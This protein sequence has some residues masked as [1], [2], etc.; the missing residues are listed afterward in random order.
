MRQRAGCFLS[1]IRHK[2]FRTAAMVHVLWRAALRAWRMDA[3][4]RAMSAGREGS[5]M[6]NDQIT[7][8]RALLQQAID[9]LSDTQ[10]DG[11]SP[12]WDI[13]KAAYDALRTAL[14]QP[15]VEPVAWTPVANGLPASG[16][17][18]LACYRNGMGNLRRIRA[19]WV[20][21][22]TQEVNGSD[23]C[24]CAEYDE[25]TDTFYIAQGWHERIDNWGDYSSV[26]V[27]EGEV[28]HWMPLPPAPDAAPQAQQ[29]QLLTDEEIKEAIR[30]LYQDETALQM[31]MD[32]T[33]HEFRAIEQAVHQ[34]A[35]LK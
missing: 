27:T 12:Q 33:L 17:V 34:K 29:P 28:T 15:A 7:V 14:E 32:I 10:K 24:E 31:S 30:H 3:A 18:V 19:E 6:T 26:A 20:A 13:E 8:S 1:S 23:E 9:A 22:K 2:E 11:E 25:A 5:E 21:A 4:M 35:G 16:V